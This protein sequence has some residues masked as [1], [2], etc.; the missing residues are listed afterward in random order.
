[1]AVLLP[2]C[3]SSSELFMMGLAANTGLSPSQ[4]RPD[5]SW[6]HPVA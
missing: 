4:Q 1:M 5:T 3:S 2:P 6:H